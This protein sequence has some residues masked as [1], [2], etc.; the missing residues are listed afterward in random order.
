MYGR[1]LITA[2]ISHLTG[3]AKKAASEAFEKVAASKSGAAALQGAAPA[4]EGSQTSP[5]SSSAHAGSRPSSRGATTAPV[6]PLSLDEDA[7][8]DCLHAT[9]HWI[10]IAAD[11]S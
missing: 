3:P 4:S 8:K 9:T 5:G 10:V 6:S 1:G 2:A 11:K 7:I